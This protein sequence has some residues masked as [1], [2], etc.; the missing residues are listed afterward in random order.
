M[1]KHRENSRSNMES[2][3]FLSY[4]RKLLGGRRKMKSPKGAQNCGTIDSL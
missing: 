3:F 1:A 2:D 4:Y